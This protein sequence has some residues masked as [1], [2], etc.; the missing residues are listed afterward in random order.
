MEERSMSLK[1][2]LELWDTSI[3]KVL[4][5][6]AQIYVDE[7]FKIRN[8]NVIS[9]YFEDF[10]EPYIDVD[11]KTLIGYVL[12][13]TTII[14]EIL[15]NGY[16]GCFEGLLQEIQQ[17]T[18]INK[19]ENQLTNI[20]KSIFVRKMLNLDDMILKQKLEPDE[21]A[22]LKSILTYENWCDIETFS[23]IEEQIELF[24]GW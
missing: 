24:F 7:Y 19:L 22:N 11:M 8:R 12:E 14:N 2:Y 1:Q 5:D 17:R 23:E 20:K 15:E 18:L 16:Q 6:L 10:V 3:N 21:M 13:D 4:D 9:H